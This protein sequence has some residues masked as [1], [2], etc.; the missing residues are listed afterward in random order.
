M[1]PSL[2]GKLHHFN[3]ASL[4]VLAGANLNKAQRKK[5]TLENSLLLIIIIKRTETFSFMS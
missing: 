1:N 3:S 2:V 5:S 4:L